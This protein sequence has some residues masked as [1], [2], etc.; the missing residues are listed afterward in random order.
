M[1]IFDTLS[2]VAQV[3][4]DD[5][6]TPESFKIG[7]KFEKYTRKI[8]FPESKYKLLKITHSYQQ[9]KK[10]YVDES[11]EPDFKF[12]CL[13]TK[14]EFYVEAKFRSYILDNGQLKFSYPEQFKRYKEFSHGKIVFIIIGIGDDPSNPDHVSLI[15][16][17]DI[18]NIYLTESFIEKY[19]IPNNRPIASSKLW[20]L[21]QN[22]KIKKDKIVSKTSKIDSNANKQNG[23]CIRCHKSV[24][25]NMDKPL[26]KNCY[27]EWSEYENEDYIESYCH[28]CGIEKNNISF[29]KPVCYDCYKS[30]VK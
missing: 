30:C 20:S 3:I 25:F 26:C 4:I 5:I 16:L 23:Y 19:A 21:I 10:D 29:A 14:Q 22:K 27:N 13:E 28:K 6:N 11:K 12:L 7:E 9:N 18:T 17:D 15:P 2:K 8:I 24:P 1:G